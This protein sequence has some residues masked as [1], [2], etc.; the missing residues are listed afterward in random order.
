MKQ[1]NVCKLNRIF[2]LLLN[3]EIAVRVFQPWLH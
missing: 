1:R 2:F 3:F